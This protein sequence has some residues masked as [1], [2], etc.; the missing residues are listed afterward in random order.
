MTGLAAQSVNADRKENDRATHQCQ[1]YMNCHSDHQAVVPGYGADGT[2]VRLGRLAESPPHDYLPI[3]ISAI[4]LP[5][6]SIGKRTVDQDEVV[7]RRR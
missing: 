3:I 2:W 5:A 7:C 6:A 4:L 1:S